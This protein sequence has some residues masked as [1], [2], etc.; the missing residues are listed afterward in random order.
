MTRDKRQRSSVREPFAGR[1]AG[2]TSRFDVGRPGKDGGSFRGTRIDC[3]DVMVVGMGQVCEGVG[4]WTELAVWISAIKTPQAK[5]IV[6]LGPAY[7]ISALS[8]VA[9][10][11]NSGPFGKSFFR[12]ASQKLGCRCKATASRSTTRVAP[13]CRALCTVKHVS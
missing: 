7:H 9:S 2:G 5:Y 8:P 13:A 12:A 10:G 3:H 11:H 1:V 4:M 6:G